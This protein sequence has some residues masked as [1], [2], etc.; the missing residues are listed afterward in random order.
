MRQAVQQLPEPCRRLLWLLF[1]EP[2]HPSYAVI[3]RELKVSS[4]S[5]GPMRAR[6]LNRLREVLRDLGW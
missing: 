6:C 1:F 4:N 3:A 5:I 2:A